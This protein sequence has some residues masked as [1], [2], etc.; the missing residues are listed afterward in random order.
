MLR[1]SL[2]RR[3]PIAAA[4]P[5]AKSFGPGD[6]PD[7]YSKAVPHP[8]W[9][10][11]MTSEFCSLVENNTWEYADVSAL[12]G[13][14]AIGCR[15]VYKTKNNHDGSVRYKARLVIKGYE[16]SLVGETFAPVARLT[17]FR[18]LIALCARFGWPL[19]HMDVVTAFLNPAVEG[20]IFMQLPD[21][22]DWLQP[23]RAANKENLVLRLRKALYGLK[24]A[25]RLWYKDIVTNL[26]CATGMVGNE[27]Y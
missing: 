25:P 15:W 2:R 14:K 23:D 9:R 24:E 20:E 21:G 19:H 8:E 18:A 3:L 1:R 7:T 5:A 22:L 13:Q 10:Q 26:P 4:M 16:Q 12:N 6:D 27:S 11:A 17:S